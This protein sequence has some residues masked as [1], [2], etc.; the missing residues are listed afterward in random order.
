MQLSGSPFC[1]TD[2]LLT[3]LLAFEAVS[4]T[5]PTCA[6]D[7]GR[8]PLLNSSSCLVTDEQVAKD[9]AEPKKGGL[10]SSFVRSIGK[11]VMGTAA[12][13][14]EDI[15]PALEHLHRK[16]MERNVAHEIARK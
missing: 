9:A 1:R 12:L 8:N 7:T 13:T 4:K 16:L 2:F 14:A 5:P 10:L 3:N 15:A 11:N 6:L